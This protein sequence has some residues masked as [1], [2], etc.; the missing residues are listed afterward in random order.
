[1]NTLIVIAVYAVVFG[2]FVY[3]NKRIGYYLRKQITELNKTVAI[4]EDTIV[5]HEKQEAIMAAMLEHLGHPI[6]DESP[7]RVDQIEKLKGL[8][9]E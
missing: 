4:L 8:V 1:M 2:I 6:G 5:L 3:A 9:G 7:E